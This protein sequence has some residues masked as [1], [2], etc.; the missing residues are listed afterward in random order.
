MKTFLLSIAAVTLLAG[1]NLFGASSDGPEPIEYTVTVL[2]PDTCHKA[3]DS[4][5]IKATPDGG[6]LVQRVVARQEGPCKKKM[7]P[8]DI[9]GEVVPETEDGPVILEVLDES[10][11]VL[12][13]FKLR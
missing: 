5:E 2:S 7:G 10:A 8:V 11:R 9:S 13:T 12:S 6:T 1:C 4:Q 3:L